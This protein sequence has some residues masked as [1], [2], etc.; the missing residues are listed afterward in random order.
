MSGVNV[1]AHV[2]KEVIA[3]PKRGSKFPLCSVPHEVLF[4]L[5]Y[6]LTEGGSV[7]HRYIVKLVLGVDFVEESDEFV[8][9]VF[10]LALDRVGRDG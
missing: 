3:A 1:F 4:P 7:R 2:R 9:S 5:L 8:F 6:L 10:A